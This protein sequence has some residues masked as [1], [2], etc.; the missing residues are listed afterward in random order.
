MLCMQHIVSMNGMY[1]IPILAQFLLALQYQG[2]LTL[3]GLLPNQQAQ[4]IESKTWVIN[5]AALEPGFATI[6][7]F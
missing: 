6:E 1:Q 5:V 3:S 2:V 7:K 4:P